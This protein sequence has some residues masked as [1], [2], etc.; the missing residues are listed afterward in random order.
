MP[1]KEVIGGDKV[2]DRLEQPVYKVGRTTGLTR[3]ILEIVGLQR[4]PIRIDDQHY[5]YTNVLAVASYDNKPFSKAGDSGALVYT[6]DGCAIGL[7]IAGT[8][9]VSYL[10][11]LDACL[12]DIEATLLQ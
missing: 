3:G 9:Q 6:E 10:S 7:V 8:D 4:Q 2:A 1:I 11:P 12:R 5:I